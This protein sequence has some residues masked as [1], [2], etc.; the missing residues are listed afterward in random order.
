MNASTYQ[1]S[2]GVFLRILGLIYFIAFLSFWVQLEGLVGENGILPAAGLL[3]LA[4]SQIGPERYWLLPTLAWID[5]NDTVLHLICMAGVIGS[6]ALALG[7]R[8]SVLL[9]LLWALYLSVVTVGRDFMEF[10]WDSLLLETGFLAIFLASSPTAAEWLFRWLLFRLM[11]SSGVVKLRSGDL[12]WRHLTALAFH[13]ETQ[14]LPTWIG[15]FMHQLPLG[16]HKLSCVVMFV[17]EIAIPFLIFTPRVLRNFAF[18]ALVVFQVLIAAAGN[19]CFFNLLTVA[20]CLFLVDDETW[21]KIGA[22]R[23]ATV[24][25]VV[26]PSS[27]GWTKWLIA[28]F[29][30]VILL[31][32]G[33]QMSSLVGLGRRWPLPAAVLYQAVSPFRSINHYGLFAVMTTTRPEIIVEGSNDGQTWL[34]YEFKWKAGDVKRRPGFVAPHQPRLDWQMW[35]AALGSHE[36]NPW[37]T[38]FMQKLLQGSPE[39]LDLLKKNP[40]PSAAPVYLRAILYDYHFTDLTSRKATGNWWKREAQGPYY[41]VLEQPGVHPT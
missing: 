16:F 23:T 12:T 34:P 14:P 26:S 37:F 22:K 11:F 2:R 28:P 19:Y 8:R 6:V 17:V 30:A 31:V 29:A 33:M 32:S 13:Y 21:L 1:I 5:P 4:Q 18:A 3:K 20:L 36:N 24:H 40:F 25:A 15:W 10:Q 27:G 35:F 7:V 38:A 41:P 9:V 39:V